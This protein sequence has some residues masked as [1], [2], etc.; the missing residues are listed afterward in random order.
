MS[1]IIGLSGL[2]LV[3][4]P[5]IFGYNSHPTAMWTSIILGVVAGFAALIKL[6]TKDTS[7]WPYWLAAIAGVLTLLAPFV[8]RFSSITGALWTMLLLGLLIAILA[9]I[10]AF[11]NPEMVAH[12]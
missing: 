8:L 6:T 10:K 2:A 9:G 5:F 7:K 4:A 3:I 11:Q 12:Q 1:W